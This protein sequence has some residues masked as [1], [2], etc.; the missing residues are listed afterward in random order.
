MQAPPASLSPE[1]RALEVARI[2]AAGLPRL[3]E[4]PP[5]SVDPGEN[6]S[7][8][9]PPELSLNCLELPGETRLNG[10]TS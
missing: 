7:P 6:P 8:K 5:S 1:E 4:K 2:L 3:S 9:K 10:H